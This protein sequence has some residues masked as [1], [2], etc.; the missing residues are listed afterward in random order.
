MKP[1]LGRVFLAAALVFAASTNLARAT[2]PMVG[3]IAPKF[4]VMT[5]DGRKLSL[6]DLQGK[7]VVVN[8]WATWC[9]PCKVELPI[10]DAYYRIQR[11]FGLEVVAVTTEDSIPLS[12]LRPLSKALAMPM[13]YH[14]RGRGYADVKAVPTNYVIGRDGIIRYARAGAF[15]LDS[16]ND[17]LVP[18]LNEPTPAP[19]GG[20]GAAL[21]QSSD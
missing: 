6:A 13:A 11:K 21:S 10:L 7:V 18:L 9:G 20:E 12:Q 8:F 15:D 14:F 4:E 3:Q 17:I 19:L 2:T 5:F 16:L 1:N